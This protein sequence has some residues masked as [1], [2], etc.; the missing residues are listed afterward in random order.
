[1]NLPTFL[2]FFCFRLVTAENES[3]IVYSEQDEKDSDDGDDLQIKFD[4]VVN[5]NTTNRELLFVY[6]SPNMQRLYRCYASS[7]IMLQHWMQLTV[8]PSM[9]CLFSLWL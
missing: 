8:Q 9:H 7:Q 2:D 3:N 6:Q 1:M 4:K 5:T